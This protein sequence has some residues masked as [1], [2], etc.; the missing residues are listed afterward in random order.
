MSS[1]DLIRELH[2]LANTVES[3]RMARYHKVD[4]LYLG[5]RVPTVTDVARQYAKDTAG[6]NL[7]GVCEGLWMT[8]I[9]EARILVG[10][11]LDVCKPR[12]TEA[13]WAFIDRVK[14]DLDA[15]AIADHLE[16]GAR[17]CLMDDDSRLDRIESAWLLH[18]NFWVRRASLVYT[19]YLSKRG[20]NPKRPLGWASGMVDDPEWFIQK[21]IGWWLRELSKHNPQRVLAFLEAY[22]ER[23]KP[24]ARREA[25]KYLP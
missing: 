4:R 23:M 16:A 2:A 9:H 22:G 11:L 13:V 8:N 18:P 17:R 5:V 3:E 15:W 10:K 12:E 7:I 19:L 14:E 21:A 20:R 1:D 6:N 25:S 24:F